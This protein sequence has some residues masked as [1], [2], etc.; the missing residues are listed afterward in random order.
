MDDASN[1]SANQHPSKPHVKHVLPDP[2]GVHVPDF[3]DPELSLTL[4]SGDFAPCKT[5]FLD[6][7]WMTPDLHRHIKSMFPALGV[8][9]NDTRVRDKEL[10]RSLFHAMQRRTNLRL[11]SQT[12]EASSDVV[13]RQM[14]SEC[15][16][17]GKKIVWFFHKPMRKKKPNPAEHADKREYKVNQSQKVQCKCP[18]EIKFSLVGHVAANK[19]PDVFLE[20][21]INQT[22][23]QHS[24]E[25]SPVFLCKG[26]RRDGHLKL[27]IPALQTA[28]NLLR[29]NPNKETRILRP[30]LVKALLNWHAL[31]AHFVSNSLKRVIKHWSIHGCFED[32]DSDLMMTDTESLESPSPSPPHG[33]G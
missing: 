24:C 26:K 22:I 27:D 17:H 30:Y 15:V 11:S 29:L 14:G 31:D 9:E 21:K 23:F 8:I 32:E 33:R 3:K 28:L 25:L 1:E 2:C 5:M 6:S 19:L 12:A 10:S 4:S 18:F 7:D 16:Q 13:P 20:V